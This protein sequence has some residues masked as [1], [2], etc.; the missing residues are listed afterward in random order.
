VV[1]ANGVDESQRLALGAELEDVD[2][3]LLIVQGRS[4]DLAAYGQAA[5]RLEHDRLCFV[6]SHS[7][8]LA[9]DWLAKLADAFDRPGVG[10]VGATGSWASLRSAA[11][12]LLFLP[13]PYRE[14]FPARRV[15]REQYRAMASEREGSSAGVS[16]HAISA[17]RLRSPLRWRVLSTLA[18]LPEQLLRFRGFPNPHLRTNA[19][20]VAR[21]TFASL[22]S[23]KITR[24]IDAYAFESGHDS[25][26]RQIQRLGHRALVVGCDGE[27]YEISEWP[28]SRTL[29]QGDQENLLVS[30]N[31]TRLYASGRPELQRLLSAYAWGRR[32]KPRAISERKAQ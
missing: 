20:M 1:L 30:D 27:S 14:V 11:L 29:W 12:N 6:N 3:Q 26:T 28:V 22:R 25:L 32:A 16:A 7:E 17:S 10:L 23:E 21:E 4:Q 9:P 31:Q 5:T 24:K 15:M 19:F 2:H 18:P 8:I 13:N